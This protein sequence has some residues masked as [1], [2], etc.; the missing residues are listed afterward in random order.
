MGNSVLSDAD[1]WLVGRGH[2]G[3]SAPPIDTFGK[4]QSHIRPFVQRAG[5]Q[6]FPT[7]PEMNKLQLY[8]ED[9]G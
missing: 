8:V 6:L 5:K 7:G 9:S 4:L 2:P 3:A 1:V